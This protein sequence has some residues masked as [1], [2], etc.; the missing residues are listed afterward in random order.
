MIIFAPICLMNTT[1]DF[2]KEPFNFHMK[3]F[4]FTSNKSSGKGKEKRHVYDLGQLYYE[5]LGQNTQKTQNM[6]RRREEFG[7]GS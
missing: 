4:Y 5:K 6:S 3:L 2:F 1:R 7:R